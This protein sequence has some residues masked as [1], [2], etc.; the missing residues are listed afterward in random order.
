MS[1]I[2]ILITYHD[3]HKVL[4]S[5]ILTPIQTGCANAERLFDGML[6]DDDGENISAENPKYNELSAQYW[7]WKN[8]NKL[9]NP[10]YIGFMHYRRHF[11]FDD[12]KKRPTEKWL[13]AS[14]WYAFDKINDDYLEFLADD[15]IE[16]AVKGFDCI[17]PK[18]YD[19]TNYMYKNLVEDYKNLFAQKIEHFHLMLDSVKE[20]F[21]DYADTA[22]EVRNGHKKY[23]ANMFIMQKAMF[24]EY[25]NF[26]FKIEKRIDEKID[27]EFFNSYEMRFL[28]FLGEILLTVFIIQKYKEKKYLIKEMDTSFIQNTN[29]DFVAPKPYFKENYAVIA[30]SSS[31]EYAPYLSVWLQ[32]ILDHASKNTNYDIFVFERGISAENKKKLQDSINCENIHLRF[33]NPI[34]LLSSYDL[35]FHEDYNIECYFRLCSPLILHNFK[36]V[37]FTD[38]DLIFNADPKELYDTPV[39]DKPLAACLDLVW[40]AFVQDPKADWKEYADKVLKLDDPFGYFNTGVML[41]NIPEFNKNDYSRKIIERCAATHYR[42]LEQDALNAFFQKNIFYLNTAWNFPTENKVFK[43]GNLF[44]FMPMRFFKQYKAD[45]KN[46]KI[47]HWAGGGKPWKDPSEDLAYLWWKYAHKTP[48]YEEILARLTAFQIQQQGADLLRLVMHYHRDKMK[49]WRYKILSKI[50]FGK[51]RKKYHEKS[52]KLRRKIK[53]VH[54]FMKKGAEKK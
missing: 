21:P 48:F 14:S 8:Y 44:Q 52:E 23:I 32:S 45:R 49:Y 26:L 20:V 13:P 54:R 47:I 4:K 6:R 38:V 43:A 29:Q 34:S 12:K 2:K 35:K 15:K 10:D 36:K 9:G 1:N 11:L 50:T 16:Q 31:N 17:V 40:G 33:V 28:G 37:V 53:E 39:D 19:Y 18:A 41:L 30:A 46:P 22:E 7:A 51:S 25:C 3:E 24:D 42:I 27:S 5:D